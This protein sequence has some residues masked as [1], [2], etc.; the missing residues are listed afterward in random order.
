[1]DNRSTDKRD[2]TIEFMLIPEN[3]SARV[4]FQRKDVS[5][6]LSSDFT[7]PD[8]LPEIRKLLKITPSVSPVSRYI[9]GNN[10]E[11]SGRVDYELLYVSGDGGIASAPLGTDFSFDV[12]L[13]M[14][15]YM[16]W[17]EGI[18]ASADIFVDSLYCR[19]LAPRKVGVKCRL[20]SDVRAYGR[21]ELRISGISGIPDA[22]KLCEKI[23]CS[24]IHRHISE[25][26][27]TSEEIPV[28]GNAESIRPIRCGASVG[29]SESSAENGMINC[30]GDIVFHV[31]YENKDSQSII[32]DTKKVPFSQSLEAPELDGGLQADCSVRGICGEISAQVEDGK[33]VVD[34]ELILEADTAINR[35]VTVTEDVFTASAASDTERRMF[36]HEKAEKCGSDTRT[37]TLSAPLADLSMSSE[38]NVLDCSATA[39][40]EAIKTDKNS[41]LIGGNC[42]IWALSESGGEYSSGELSLPFTFDSE[43]AAGKVCGELNFSAVPTVTD[44]RCRIDGENAFFDIDLSVSYCI[45][46]VCPLPIVKNVSVSEKISSVPAGITVYYPQKGETLWDAAKKFRVPLRTLAEANNMPSFSGNEPLDSKHFL[47]IC[48]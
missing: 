35:S 31:L 45:T 19:V 33:L 21:E 46:S 22:E 23:L 2:K 8:Y 12:Q 6:E 7:L 44:C 38:S 27:E 25:I 9:S 24:D 28:S 36:R 4:N 41:V 47:M 30:R 40:A 32:S 17:D 10:V 15:E 20:H 43:L 37:I 39:K 26:F 42:K 29:I 5:T 11:F 3:E 13:E 18:D 34:A 16:D 48:K 14:P 1:M